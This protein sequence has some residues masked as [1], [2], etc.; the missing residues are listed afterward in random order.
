MADDA[1]QAIRE[2]L[3]WT[4]AGRPPVRD[5]H[6]VADLEQQVATTSDV[7]EKLRLLSELERAASDDHAQRLRQRF[8]DSARGWAEHNGVTAEAFRQLGVPDADLRDAGLLGRGRGRSRTSRRHGAG[9]LRVS[10]DEIVAAVPDRQ[11]TKADLVRSSGASPGA[12]TA[13]LNEL[14]DAGRVR[15]VGP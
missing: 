12:V 6:R 14:V 11:F 7:I 15:L 9:R 1:E 8:V 13:A 4:A 2:Y 10:R 5:E 3:D